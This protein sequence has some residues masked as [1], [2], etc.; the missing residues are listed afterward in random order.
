MTVTTYRGTKAYH[1]VFSELISA[2]RYR[3]NITYQE[4]ARLMGL[5]LT[6]NYMGSRVSRL[7]SEI[8]ED[9]TT[10]GR[11]ILSAI[12]VN[13]KGAPG[14]G[15]FDMARTLGRLDGSSEK[16]ER[17]FLRREAR[18]VYDCWKTPPC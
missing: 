1:L 6:G 7:L 11:P 2:A 10:A 9:E 5:P 18:A 14:K 16:A 13:A 4:I 3:G 17:N 8:A 12:V 15:F